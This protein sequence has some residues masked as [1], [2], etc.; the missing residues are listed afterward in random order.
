M[1]GSK[2]HVKA[3][4]PRTFVLSIIVSVLSAIICMQIISRIGITP[5]TSIIGAIVAM[6]LARIPLSFLKDFRSLD[7][8]NLV[9]TMTSASG[10]GAANCGL[11]AVGIIYVLG[12]PKY[13]FPMLIGSG[14]ATVI[15]MHFVYK[16][17]DSDL[18]PAT[19]A[20]PPGI[21]TAQALI[22]GDEGGEK[23]RR[24]L[25]GVVVGAIGSHFGLP[26][27]G[28]GIVF[29]ANIFAMSALGIGL[30]IRGYSGVLL[31]LDLG[32]TYIPHGVMIGA[33]IVSLVQALVVISRKGTSSSQEKTNDSLPN[34][35]TPQE[36]KKAIIFHTILFGLGAIVLALLSGLW[37]DMSFG[38]LLLWVAWAT[39]SAVVAPILVGL[40]AMHS[41]WFPGFAISVIFLSL[42]LFMGFPGVPLAL[43]A[44]Y[45]SSTGPCFA[46]MGYDLK[47]GWIIRGK[48]RD[49]E[50]ELDGRR[51]QMIAEIIGGFVA[52]VVVF[53]FMNM[54]FKLDMLPPVSRVFA[55]TVYAGANPDVLRQLLLWSVAGAVIQLL[56]GAKRAIGILFATGLLIKNPIY[57]IGVL[58]AVICRIIW[59]TKWMEMREA[60]LIAG[61]G[62]Y[63]FISAVVRSFA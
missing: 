51:Q 53:F 14:I 29:I 59:G 39:F 28:V 2:K 43:L 41:G 42:G 32:K 13:I 45:V 44:G 58:A 48:G 40:S 16:I 34:T 47:T 57:G 6:T 38:K 36:T 31:G 11:L 61:D 10:F 22:A 3:L 30:V 20:W 12:A 4:E 5:N 52:V 62:I 60:G 21:A 8:Q 63:G 18:Y 15:G 1:N 56:G 50:Y 27:A 37:R 55:A 49:R 23:A 19:G 7:R 24:L 17:Y 46:D 54:H 9:Q 33:G 25:E 35:V 26:M